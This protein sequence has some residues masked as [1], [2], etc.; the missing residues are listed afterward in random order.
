MDVSSVRQTDSG[1]LENTFPLLPGPLIILAP[2][3]LPQSPHFVFPSHF[4]CH[5]NQADVES[6]LRVRLVFFL[7]ISQKFLNGLSQLNISCFLI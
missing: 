7:L 6:D 2:S 5:P 1:D 4:V 3:T